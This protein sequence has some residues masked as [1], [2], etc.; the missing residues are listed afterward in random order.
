MLPHD[1]GALAVGPSEAV[2]D[3]D[4]DRFALVEILGGLGRHGGRAYGQCGR[5]R[6]CCC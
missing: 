1:G 5:G 3:I 6:K 2:A 4:F